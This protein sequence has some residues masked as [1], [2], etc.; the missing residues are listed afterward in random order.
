M[1]NYQQMDLHAL[2]D[3]LAI[4]TQEYTKAYARGAQEEIAVHRI[5][6]DALITEIRA[7]K[8]EDILPQNVLTTITPPEQP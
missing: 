2:I 3:L 1:H 5:V 4:E 7:R 6:M 8:K